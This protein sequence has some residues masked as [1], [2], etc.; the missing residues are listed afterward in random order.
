MS[1]SVE[2]EREVLTQERQTLDRRRQ[3]FEEEQARVAQVLDLFAYLLL[4]W[5]TCC[6]CTV[7]RL[8]FYP[9]TSGR[10]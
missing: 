10:V 1:A 3:E 6:L 9:K 4:K 5:P 7:S 2:R 8:I